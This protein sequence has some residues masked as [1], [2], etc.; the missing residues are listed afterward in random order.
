MKTFLQQLSVFILMGSKSVI[1]ITLISVMSVSF[2][3]SALADHDH[4]EYHGERRH[5][6]HEYRGR[7]SEGY[8]DYGYRYQQPY[9]YSQP[10]YVPPPV[11]Y[12]PQPSP[13]ISLI[14]PL[15]LRIR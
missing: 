6:D 3:P 5:G 2:V 15:N 13:G 1:F 9:S 7:R 4:D 12:P 11:Y 14:L 10:V 8:D